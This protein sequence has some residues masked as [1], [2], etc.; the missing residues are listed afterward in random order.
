MASG[1]EKEEG[2]VVQCHS[3]WMNRS[4]P[5]QLRRV[6]RRRSTTR[7]HIAG[8]AIDLF[9][10]RGFDAVSVDDVAQAAGIAR[11]TLFRY[12]ASKS[13][14]IW[15]DFDTH[16]AHLR[17]LLALH[18]DPDVPLCAA[19]RSA[20]LAFN[21][22]DESEAV[23]HRARMRVILETAELQ[24][25]SM[26]MYAGWREVIA[27]FVAARSRRQDR[28]P[29]PA[30]HRVDDARCGIVGLSSTGSTM[31]RCR[32]TMPSMPHS[33][34]SQPDSTV[35][36]EN[37]T[38]SPAS[39]CHRVAPPGRRSAQRW[40]PRCTANCWNG[41]PAMSRVAVFAAMLAGRESDPIGARWCPRLLRALL[42]VVLDGDRRGWLA[43]ITASADRGDTADAPPGSDAGSTGRRT[44]RDLSRI[45]PRLRTD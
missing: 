36:P 6:G 42:A 43:G 23:Q 34:W 27:D 12:Y 30:D 14:I 38:P 37:A 4:I 40:A 28:R 3:T 31:S 9:S 44:R 2:V 20:L 8:L 33:T 5:R 15:G 7:D 41:S 17:T 10:T 22:F 19:L 11:R 39:H 35:W 1:A 18:V 29:G 45:S 21:T 24:A 32:C 26:T 16:L 25:Y 13:A